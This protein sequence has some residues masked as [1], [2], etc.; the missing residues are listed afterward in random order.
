MQLT[1]KMAES[2]QDAVLAAL[3]SIEGVKIKRSKKTKKS[4]KNR[5]KARL[6]EGFRSALEEVKL[7]RAGK[8]ELPTFRQVMDEIDAELLEAE[9]K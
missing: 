2:K 5:D 3:A 1:I 7:H 9:S 6:I 8:I 4:K